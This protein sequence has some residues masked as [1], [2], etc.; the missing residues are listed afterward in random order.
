MPVQQLFIWLWP[1]MARQ[2]PH[3]YHRLLCRILGVTVLVDGTPPQASSLIVANHVSWLDI[4]VLSAATPCSFIA[5]REVGTWPLF[6]TMARLQRTIF[7]DRTRRLSTVDRRDD[8]SERLAEGGALVL[9]AE[10]TSGDGASVRPF[11]SSFFA[12]ADV[13]AKIVPTTLAYLNQWNMPLTRRQR[14]SVAWYG[15]MDM[16]PHLWALLKSGPVTVRVIFHDP[17]DTGHRKHAAR[18]AEQTIRSSLASALHG[19]R[20]LL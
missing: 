16:A 15:D 5:K 8:M 4:V 17:L 9:F 11:K 1:D 20:D 13:N 7:V 19:P 18:E 10:G 2:F 14:P 12:A 6:G 3:A